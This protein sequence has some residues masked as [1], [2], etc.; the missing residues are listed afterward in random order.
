MVV[1]GWGNT[2]TYHL[3]IITFISIVATYF[4]RKHDAIHDVVAIF[5]KM[6]RI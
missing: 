3:F 5:N 2:P 6:V 1:V 4:F